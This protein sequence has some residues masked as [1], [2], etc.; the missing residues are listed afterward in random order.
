M[1]Y[2]LLSIYIYIYTSLRFY[3][4][5]MFGQ[6]YETY[7]WERLMLPD[8]QFLKKKEENQLEKPKKC[9]ILVVERT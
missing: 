5:E 2:A 6:R 9:V 8:I 4:Y 7:A 3:I 1:K